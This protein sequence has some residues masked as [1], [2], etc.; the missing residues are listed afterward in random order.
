MRGA[1]SLPVVMYHYVND[2]RGG[3]TLA[4]ER[5]EEHCRALAEKGWRGVSL[6]EAEAFFMEGEA[7]P[8]RSL[9]LTFDDGFLDNVQIAL[10]I[11]ARYGHK[12]VVFAVASRLEHGAAPRVL[13][14]DILAGRAPALPEVL[15]PLATDE[16]GLVERRDVF[17]NHAEAREADAQGVLRLASHS[18]GHYGVFTG[19]EYTDFFKP[20]NTPRTFYRTEMEP[21]WGL[22][23]FPVSAGLAH[24]AFLPD[25]ALVEAVRALVPQDKAGAVRFFADA[26]Q[27]QELAQLVNGFAGRLGRFE[28]DAER[29]RR[30]Q[31]ELIGGKEAL[32]AILG[33]SVKTLCWPWGRYCD[34]AEALA[35]E[36]GF[37]VTVTTR[38][39]VNPP[40]RAQRICRF[41]GKD[42]SGAWLVS[43]AAIYARP[44]LGAL[45]AKLRI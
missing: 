45:Y 6:E 29:T 13:L 1:Q 14:D 38:E 35:R 5:F 25:P 44:W 8:P 11:L 10:P 30:M 7:L 33:R 18:L 32:E 34:E 12:A 41:K 27:V 28:T 16:H 36:A 9:L 20:A 26:G 39:G 19:P 43:R 15:R 23:D 22:P 21:V 4:P 17:M 37:A 2:D 40:G 31:K 24:R 3:I 42:K